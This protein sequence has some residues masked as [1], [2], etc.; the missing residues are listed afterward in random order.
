MNR[1]KT[2]VIDDE[3]FARKRIVKLLS[4]HLSFELIGQC[5]NGRDAYDMIIDK[6][7]DVIFLD[8]EMPVMSG[9]ELVEKLPKRGRPLIVFVTAYNNYA[10]QAFNF[11]A[12]DYLLKPF[13]EERFNNTIER[14]EHLI[15]D[16]IKNE[17]AAQV[18]AFL[19][20]L[21]SDGE[22]SK[23]TRKRLPVPL[24]NKIYFIDIPEIQYV[25][26][27]GNYVNVFVNN[28]KHVLRETLSSFER[29]LERDE[30][31]RIHKSFII[32]IE[33]IKEIKK[34]S[35][36]N[37]IICMSNNKTFNVSKTYKSDL[38]KRLL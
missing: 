20:F 33:F 6:Q 21:N 3:S 26:A 16:G 22:I 34:T 30:F 9:I 13:T 23:S 27:S 31:V 2:I 8:I 11:F 10:I 1:I 28:A 4:A 38:L 37:Y 5:K 35:T 32:N 17:T 29:K 25:I 15:G 24:G 12:L 18:N 36:G 14:I 7:P 19:Q